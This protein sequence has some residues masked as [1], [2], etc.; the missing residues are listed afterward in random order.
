MY[1]TYRKGSLQIGMATVHKAIEISRNIKVVWDAIRYAGAIRKSLLPGTVAD[2]K[3][4]GD[5]RIDT[6][7]NGMVVRELIAETIRQG[8]KHDETNTRKRPPLAF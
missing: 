3:F 4:E 5:S 2:C 6:V 1:M 8:F 7:P